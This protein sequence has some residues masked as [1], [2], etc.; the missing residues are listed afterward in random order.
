MNA[1]SQLNNSERRFTFNSDKLAE[2]TFEVARFEG[3]EALSALYRFELLLVSRNG[4]IDERS[5]VGTSAQLSLNDGV[6]NGNAT[7]Y[8]GLIQEFSYEYR[9]ESWTFYRAILA[10]KLWT[11]NTYIL[12]EVY[13]NKNRPEIF[14]TILENA[15]LTHNDFDLRLSDSASDAFR[16]DYI[17]QYRESYWAFISRWA[18]RLGIYWWYEEID[19]MEKAIFTDTR[20]V[21]NDNAITLHYQPPGEPEAGI[22]RTRAYQSLRRIAQNLPRQLVIRDYSAD[23]ASQELKGTAQV[24]QAGTGEIHLFGRK[25]KSNMEIEQRARLHAEMLLCRADIF[26]GGSNATGLRCGHLIRLEQHPRAGFNR[27]YLLTEVKHRGSQA[28]LLLDGL[29]I[30]AESG[31]NDFYSAEFSA[32]PDNVQFRPEMKHAWPM[33][34]GSINAFIDAEGSGKYAELNEN[35][36]YK[37]QLPFDITQKQADRGSA[38]IRMATPYAGRDHGM[39]FP[40]HK[41]TEVLL[42]FINGDPDQPVIIAAVPNSVTPN[43]V[44]NENETQSRIQ[45]AGGNSLEFEDMENRQGIHLF[46]PVA[47]TKIHIG[48]QPPKPKAAGSDTSDFWQAPEGHGDTVEG[49]LASG[50]GNVVSGELNGV[51]IETGGLLFEAAIGRISFFAASNETITGAKTESVTGLS[52][53]I[54]TGGKIETV[55][56]LCT[57][58]VA[59]DKTETITGLCTETVAGGKNETVSGLC[60]ENFNGD[61]TE[62]VLG[63]LTENTTGLKTETV[64]GMC[65]ERFN[66]SKYEYIVGTSTESVL[67]D[68][69]ETTTGACVESIQGDKTETVTGDCTETIIGDKTEI[70][71]GMCIGNVTGDKT[72]TISGSLIDGVF[73]DR[74]ETTVGVKT[75]ISTVK[76]QEIETN[77]LTATILMTT[78]CAIFTA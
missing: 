66:G 11:L 26:S 78:G 23:R 15:G 52:T 69:T 2:N 55:T 31:G 68:K 51:S 43:V 72:E 20:M 45:T 59:G 38:W 58:T 34:T 27:R 21:H 49:N 70:I 63:D 7:I 61:K 8:R 53:E 71:T 14:K 75:E 17:C 41:G 4:E 54:M 16:R 28:G 46:S 10:P 6:E 25:L 76:T 42:S 37:V 67:G 57:E 74:Q 29:G 9:I 1:F 3:E 73:G 19:G 32:I 56:G 60:I 18:E 36:E 12:S 39:H 24:D 40:L 47:N 50:E 33:V 13:L 65:T 44:T 48:A 5:L 62:S 22:A 77:V 35:G 30:P 64:A